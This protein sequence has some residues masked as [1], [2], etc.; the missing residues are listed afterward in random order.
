MI[1]EIEK[2]VRRTLA[3]IRQAFRGVIG[4]VA[5]DGDVAFVQGEGLANETVSDA[6]LFQHYGLTSVPPAGSMMVVVPVG[7]K[8]S[9]GIVIATEHGT[10]RLKNLQAGEVALYTDEGDSIVLGRGRIVTVTTK[11]FKL[12]AEDS[13]EINTKSMKVAASESI[14]NDTPTVNMTHQ[15][16]VTDAISETGGLSVEGGDGV[17]IKSDVKIEGAAEVTGDVE[18]GGKSFLGHRHPETGSITDPPQ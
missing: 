9:H 8:T 13:V 12:N 6:E 15:L 5:T 18:I 2:R 4:G 1:D 16:N 17:N 10:Y 11:T 14:T 7:G 3:G